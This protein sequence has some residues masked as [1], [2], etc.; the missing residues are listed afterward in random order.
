MSSRVSAF[1]VLRDRNYAFY[2][3]NLLAGALAAEVL[4]VAIGW[5]IYDISH[6][7]A[8]LA[9]VG[10]VQFLPT[11][12][13]VLATGSVADRYS[14]KRILVLCMLSEVIFAAA[15]LLVVR[16]GLQQ[17]WPI[18][19]LVAGLA[20]GRAFANPAS[21]ALAPTLVRREQIPAAIACGTV[22]WQLSSIAGPA[23][24]GLLYGFAPEIAFGAAMAMALVALLSILGIRSPDAPLPAASEGE[25]S[26]AARVSDML[27]GFKFMLKQKVVLGAA[28]LD[29]F[30]VL[31]GS[32]PA[33]FPVFAK[34]ILAAGPWGLGLL[35]SGI[36]IGAL[37]MALWLGAFPIRRKAGGIMFATVFVF[38]FGTVAF[39]L[40]HWIG[41]SIAALIVMGAAD[42]I[43]VYIREVLVQLW[44]PDA[45]RGRVNAVYML[46][47]NA[48]NELGAT[49]AGFSAWLIGP[50]AAV[51]VGGGCIVLVAALWLRL[52]P[53]LRQADDLSAVEELP[54][55]DEEAR[56]EAARASTPSLM[57]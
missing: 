13:L 39:G 6:N 14:R 50:V 9:L 15:I 24:G 38:G 19:V 45:L 17:V 28:S 26:S 46:M 31:L 53:A 43:S 25:R 20:T 30:A 11:C 3:L 2:A 7:P 51:L 4:V 23:L 56:S 41:V 55:E 37:A 32:T 29:L 36:G 22:C 10:L 27:G 33:L 57:P 49:R 34:D 48:S 44:T 16:A 54:A 52:F 21:L 8:D 47:I 18:L 35:R 12:L 1:T 42:M 40:S 5:R